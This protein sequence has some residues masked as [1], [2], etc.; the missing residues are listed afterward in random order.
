MGDNLFHVTHYWLLSGEPR[1]I[2]AVADSAPFVRSDDDA[3]AQLPDVARL[4]GV[5]TSPL[6]AGYEWDAPRNHWYYIFEG[7]SEALYVY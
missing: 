5:H 3:R 4:F 1:G 7:E 6:V 2:R